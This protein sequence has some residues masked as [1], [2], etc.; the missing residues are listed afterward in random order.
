MMHSMRAQGKCQL[1]LQFFEKQ[2]MVAPF[3]SHLLQRILRP[4]RQ[5][6]PMPAS[7]PSPVGS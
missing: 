7:T 2:P 6:D 3:L 4:R 1:Y 5:A